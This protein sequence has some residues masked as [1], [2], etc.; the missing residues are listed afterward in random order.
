MMGVGGDHNLGASPKASAPLPSK[1]GGVLGH[2]LFA[3]E[4]PDGYTL[5]LVAQLILQDRL[6]IHEVVPES[7]RAPYAGFSAEPAANVIPERAHDHP[8]NASWVVDRLDRVA[9]LEHSF[10]SSHIVLDSL[11]HLSHHSV[12]PTLPFSWC[13]QSRQIIGPAGDLAQMML[14][15]EQLGQINKVF[16]LC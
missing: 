15:P 6:P 11:Y 10:K 1:R 14:S 16:A 12:S 2:W 7:V 5:G 13:S 9:N 4:P 8:A 3:L